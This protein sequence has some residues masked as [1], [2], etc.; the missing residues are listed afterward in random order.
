ML[1]GTVWLHMV[2]EMGTC[3]DLSFLMCLIAAP[4]AGVEVRR[5]ELLS[6]LARVYIPTRPAVFECLSSFTRS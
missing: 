2:S 4:S 3:C 5:G 6:A 1:S